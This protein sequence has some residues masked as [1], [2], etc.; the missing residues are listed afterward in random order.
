MQL[1]GE[2]GPVKMEKMGPAQIEYDTSGGK[3]DGGYAY[4]KSL[5]YGIGSYRSGSGAVKVVRA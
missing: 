2:Q 1:D 3:A 4:V 5:L